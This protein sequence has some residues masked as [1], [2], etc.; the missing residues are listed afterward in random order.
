MKR[1]IGTA[2]QVFVVLFAV[3]CDKKGDDPASSS[4]QPSS[5]EKS[6]EQALSAAN[7]KSGGRI[8]DATLT[9]KACELLSSESVETFGIPAAELEPIRAM[10]CTY[11]WKSKAAAEAMQLDARFS[12]IRAHQNEASAQQWFANATKSMSQEETQKA[13][14]AVTRK[15]KEREEIDTQAKERTVDK[16]GDA[17]GGL[18]GPEGIRFESVGGVGDE[19]RLD[20]SDGGLWVRV[21][22]LT[23][24][25]SA[26]Y[27]PPA[28]KPD[29]KKVGLQEMAKAALAAEREWVQKTVTKRKEDAIK[30]ASVILKALP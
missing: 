17:L 14:A 6:V 13:V 25:V 11:R 20:L 8:F 21:G 5:G 9:K 15:T 18:A 16:V 1:S 10:G 2:A 30:L 7:E 12:A 26:Y 4:D 29:L 28:S 24:V 27:G 23:F 19:A 3:G 22:N